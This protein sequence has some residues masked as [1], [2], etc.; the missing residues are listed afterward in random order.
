MPR[1]ANATA[2]GPGLNASTR[3]SGT[4][5]SGMSSPQV[6]PESAEEFGTP[7]FIIYNAGCFPANRY[8][9]GMTSST[10]VCMHFRRK[11]MVILGTEYAGEMKKGI[12]TL[13]MY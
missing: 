6:M 2:G 4:R 3:S 11:E 1:V 12:L 5:S 13:M 7:D 8:T 9:K 10:S